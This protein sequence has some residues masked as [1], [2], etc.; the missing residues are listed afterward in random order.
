[1]RN[2]LNLIL[3][4]MLFLI[5]SSLS[6]ATSANYFLPPLKNRHLRI[7]EGGITEYRW[8]K[9]H[10]C[11]FAKL[12]IC[13]DEVIE[14]DFDLKKKEDVIRFNQM[15]FECSVRNRP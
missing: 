13:Y 4:M 11:G 2:I 9:S 3:A 12:L 7:V 5:V 10:R 15:G 1:M 14:R 8:Y 6:C